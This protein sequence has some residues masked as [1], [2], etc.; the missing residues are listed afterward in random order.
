MNLTQSL[1][2]YSKQYREKEAQKVRKRLKGTS[3]T[4]RHR[5]I[6]LLEDTNGIFNITSDKIE[7]LAANIADGRNYYTHYD[8]EKFNMPSFNFLGSASLFLRCLLL[9]IV[10]RI[11]GISDIDIKDRLLKHQQYVS[12]DCSITDILNEKIRKK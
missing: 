5:F 1:E 4:L 10:Y 12:V 9:C 6:D 7:Q 2:I 8:N 3:L 11:I